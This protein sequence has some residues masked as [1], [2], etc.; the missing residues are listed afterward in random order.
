MEEEK[1]NDNSK[2]TPSATADP[3][4]SA[5]GE[6]SPPSQRSNRTN[7]SEG[8]GAQKAQGRQSGGL[9]SFLKDTGDEARRK[10]SDIE[11][12]SAS[13]SR[14]SLRGPSEV[15]DNPNPLRAEPN[16]NADDQRRMSA[17]TPKPSSESDLLE[18]LGTSPPP[19]VFSSFAR[20][21]PRHELMSLAAHALDALA[22]ADR[23]A[24]DFDIEETGDIEEAAISNKRRASNTAVDQALDDLAKLE[25]AF[26]HVEQR[27]HKRLT[28]GAGQHMSHQDMS[29][30]Y[31]ESDHQKPEEGE[32]NQKRDRALTMTMVWNHHREGGLLVF[33]EVLFDFSHCPHETRC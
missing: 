20:G 21:M 12:H 29:L 2:P 11:M 3:V 8:D 9:I 14:A 32:F 15:R 4:V 24:L 7:N 1:Y 26:V 30:C 25:E 28:A 19:Q 33:Y 18:A 5:T 17:L 27:F 10:S 23:D 22:E 16:K 13:I 6:A 31:D